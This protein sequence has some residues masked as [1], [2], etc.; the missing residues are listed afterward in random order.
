MILA[1]LGGLYL[2]AAIAFSGALYAAD[3][4]TEAVVPV[5]FIPSSSSQADWMF[6]GLVTNEIGENYAYF[7]QMQRHD[8]AFHAIAAL[9][10]VESRKLISFDED[11][12]TIENPERYNWRVGR[13][14]L[15]FNTINNSWVFGLKSLDKK[16]FNFKVDMLNH[17]E[18]TPVAQ[19]MRA[20]IAYITNQTG[21]LNGHVQI[22]EAGKEQFVTAQHAWF[23]QIWLTNPQN[24]SH[25]FTS[26]L[27]RFSDGSGFNA[28]NMVE[29]DTVRGSV[30]S[31]FDAQGAA[32]AMSQ[33]I[34]VT[35]DKEGV[36]H[37]QVASPKMHLTLSDILKKNG[38]VAGFVSE[39]DKFGFCTLSENSLG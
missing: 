31:C 7:F 9:F 26:T 36:W 33:F 23:K 24:E 28:M 3:S 29:P 35:E 19:D 4:D 21:Q 32:C 34:H 22:D 14:F 2:S 18:N 25:A 38:V 6:S 8:N 5:G 30:A 27:C 1:R 37:I 13:S 12:A 17:P 11:S 10:D 15:R 20:G 16:G 39:K